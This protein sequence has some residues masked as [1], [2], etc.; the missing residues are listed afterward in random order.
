M[1]KLLLLLFI[2]ILLDAAIPDLTQ[3]GAVPARDAKDWNLGPTGARG[4]IYSDKYSTSEARQIYVTSVEKSSPAYKILLVGDVI[5]GIGKSKFQD[6]PRRTLGRAITQAE[7]RNG[8]LALLIWRQNKIASINLK[9][10]VLGK[11]SATSPFTC[12]KSEMIFK[13]ACENIA[14]NLKKNK[15]RSNWIVR[16]ANTLALLASGDRRYLSLIKKEVAEAAKYQG[17]RTNSYYS[18]F[19]GPVTS[20]IAEYTLATGDKRYLKDLKR[21]ALEI[22][23]GQSPVGSWGHR[24]VD[25]NG[26][27]RGYGMMNAPG[28]PLT[29]S[30]VLARKAGVKDAKFDQAIEKSTKL[31]RFYVGKGAIPYG[32]HHPWTQTHDDNGKNGMAAVLFN[33]LGDKEAAG[34]FSR[35]SVA[36]HSDEREMGHTGNFF[37][38]Q[39]ALPGVA[40][41]G[42]QASGAWMREYSWYYDLAR[43]WDGSFIHQGAPQDKK[44]SYRN[45]DTSGVMVLAY[46]QGNRNIYLT[47]KKSDL[48]EQ[49][50]TANAE[51][52]VALGRGWTLKNKHEYLNGRSDKALVLALSNWSPVMRIR[53][54]EALAKR[55]PK[56]LKPY[57]ELLDSNDLY[58]AL[59]ACELIIQMKGQAKDAVPQLIKWLDYPDLWLRI[60]AADALA[61]IG[62]PSMKAVPRMLEMF[63]E[64]SSGDPRGMLQRY[65]CF[66]LFNKRGGLL[67]KF[68]DGVDKK[69]LLEAVKIGLKNDD[70]RARGAISSVYENLEFE[71]LEPLL[72]AILDAIEEPAPSGI[73][74]ADGIRT[75]GLKLLVTHK[76]ADGLP[77]TVD[78]IKNQKKHGS[79]KRILVLIKYVESYG[80]HA[81]KEIAKMNDIIDYFEKQEEGFPKKLSMQ[82]AQYLRESIER[83]QKT[84]LRPQLKFIEK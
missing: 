35:M 3:G 49:I 20:L 28:L 56:D 34:Y 55:K 11:Y 24:F 43:R 41:S 60:K 69:D 32:D 8:I 40:L 71:E 75:A 72:P 52:I 6:D 22:V 5:I 30:L 66:A 16:S 46:A 68:L 79:Q 74:F 27:L 10:K 62:Q 63:A 13:Q 57:F 77:L 51:A 50:S 82:K 65:L 18:W 61:A 64:Q 54:A 31:L 25:P 21:I 2:P 78:Y 38:I 39:W 53:A 33:L 80:A 14:K 45:W 7:A 48:V 47:G 9:L 23:N 84:N 59:G 12:T 36:T 17:I 70:G 1:K 44:D 83:I 58:S 73:M 29:L 15:N 19:Y 37:N 26:R 76:V 4:W 81:Q 67:G 42:P